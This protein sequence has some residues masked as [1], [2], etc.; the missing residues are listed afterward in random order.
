MSTATKRGAGTVRSFSRVLLAGC[1]L[2]VTA[3][4]SFTAPT[5]KLFPTTVLEE[6]KHTGDGMMA[7]FDETAR[8]VG[9]A[10]AIQ[11]AFEAFNLSETRGYETGS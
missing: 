9:C 8:S 5:I 1:L 7:S 11:Q 10:R 3:F 2:P 4:A 6:I